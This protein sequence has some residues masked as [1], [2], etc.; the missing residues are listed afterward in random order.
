MEEKKLKNEIDAL[1]PTLTLKEIIDPETKLGSKDSN[2]FTPF[3]SSINAL[4]YA[5]SIII[6]PSFSSIPSLS[7][8]VTLDFSL[9]F[10]SPEAHGTL[11]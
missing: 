5:L 7:F 3:F 11:P 1:V 6:F 9:S 2:F 8:L 4:F 10:P